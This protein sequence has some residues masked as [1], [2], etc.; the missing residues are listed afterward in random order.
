MSSRLEELVQMLSDLE[1]TSVEMVAPDKVNVDMRY[2]P[3]ESYDFDRVALFAEALENGTVFPPVL[4]AEDGVTVIDGA[5]RTLAHRQAG[6]PA[7]PARRVLV[8]DKTDIMSLSILTNSPS[9]GMPLKKGDLRRILNLI[10]HA[11]DEQHGGAKQ[12]IRA[13]ADS[14]EGMARWFHVPVTAVQRIT[15][16]IAALHGQPTASGPPQAKT[17]QEQRQDQPEEGQWGS[18]EPPS[19]PESVVRSV[20][21][22]PANISEVLQQS[23]WDYLLQAT[24]R[25]VRAYVDLVDQVRPTEALEALSGAYLKVSSAER[26]FLRHYRDRLLALCETLGDLEE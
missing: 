7:M 1:T 14:M 17:R 18:A 24:L 16:A 20:L 8:S 11:L 3:R 21:A 10:V 12:G 15:E 13:Y 23:P 6:K 19:L 2:Y 4:L 22:A 9:L 5:H 26:E 25:V